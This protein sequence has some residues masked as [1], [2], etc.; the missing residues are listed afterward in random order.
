MIKLEFEQKPLWQWD[1]G[2]KLVLTDHP[3]GTIVDFI[4]TGFQTKSAV[5]QEQNGTVFVRIPN[6]MLRMDTDL[7]VYLRDSSESETQTMFAA[8]FPVHSRPKPDDY[9]SDG[10]EVLIWHIL[11]ERITALEQSGTGGGTPNAVQFVPQKLRPEQQ[12]QARDNIAALSQEKLQGGIHD[13]L[14]QAKES[15]AFDGPAGADGRSA[16]QL[17]QEGGYTGTEEKFN[18]SLSECAN[19]FEKDTSGWIPVVELD[20][21]K[22]PWEKSF[23]WNNK[24]EKVTTQYTVDYFASRK[25]EIQPNCDYELVGLNGEMYLYD[26]SGANGTKVATFNPTG[27][28]KFRSE[29]DRRYAAISTKISGSWTPQRVKLTRTSI[30]K[31]EY[32]VLPSNA[33]RFKP[34]FNKKV[35]FFGDSLFG[36]YRGAT[37]A[38]AYAEQN[39]G[40]KVYNVG[41]GGCKMS[42]HPMTG[43]AEF[44]MWALAQAVATGDFSAQDAAAAKGAS[45]FSEQLA[46]LK[47]IDFNQVQIAVIHYGTNDFTSNAS[48]D[49]SGNPMD[50][51]S[52]CGALRYSIAQLQK[53]Y[54]RIQ[55][56]VSLP[57]Y[58][59]WKDGG[60]TIYAEDK[61]NANGSHLTDVCSA[62]VNVAREYNLPVIDGYHG[63]NINKNNASAFLEDGTHH[64]QY[65][66]ERFGTFIGQ[67]LTAAKADY[68]SF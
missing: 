41:F 8:S 55:I 58:R 64:N 30:S 38:A 42:V 57:V 63:L 29:A 53:A 67:C 7:R 31:E 32:D 34:L 22:E 44:C 60:Q 62:L 65:G 4:Q 3:A 19:V 66:R 20:G 9:I 61:L 46:L 13:A 1:T 5:A 27:V 39:C 18:K 12:A 37:S 10:A 56:Y 15:G 45:Y 14:A 48:L 21:A 40:A 47:S 24:G 52:I 6:E 26:A 2:R 59:Y 33:D 25:F 50:Y 51:H 68:P 43:Y 54:P 35:V 17:A 28:L 49:N 36:M 23:F 16:Y 11:D